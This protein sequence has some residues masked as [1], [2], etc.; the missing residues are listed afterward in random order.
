MQPSLPAPPLW[1]GPLHVRLQVPW[2][3]GGARGGIDNTSAPTSTDSGAHTRADTKDDHTTSYTITLSDCFGIDTLADVKNK[4]L[5]EFSRDKALKGLE[6]VAVDDMLLL[7]ETGQFVFKDG[8][9]QFLSQYEFL[10]P[11][12]TLTCVLES[13][14]NKVRI[15]CVCVCVCARARVCVCDTHTTIYFAAAEEHRT[16][17]CVYTDD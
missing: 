3:A 2:G 1:E 7:S 10:G 6:G 5:I 4:L 14:N 8:D 13:P 16:Y 11:N 12:A 17:V 9:G 15:S